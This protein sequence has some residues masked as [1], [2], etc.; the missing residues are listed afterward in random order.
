MGVMPASASW[1]AAPCI[2]AGFCLC[3]HATLPCLSMFFN[4]CMADRWNATI[5]LSVIR[6]AFHS[7]VGSGSPREISVSAGCRLQ[8]LALTLL[9]CPMGCEQPFSLHSFPF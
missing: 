1:H 6:R 3:H 4:L 5:T 9:P 7:R 2:D 8:F